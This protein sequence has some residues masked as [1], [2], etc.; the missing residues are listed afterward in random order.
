MERR[1]LSKIFPEWRGREGST[2]FLFTRRVG[3][4]L[5]VLVFA[6][7]II[8]SSSQSMKYS[9]G[10]TKI[11]D[12]Q[13]AP[14][15]GT[16]SNVVGAVEGASV[17][18]RYVTKRRGT[19]WKVWDRRSVLHTDLG[20]TC[21][22]QAFK[23]VTHGGK[24]GKAPVFMCLYP[25]SEDI[26]VSGSIEGGGNWGD[27]HVLTGLLAGTKRDPVYIDIGANIGA[28]VMQV[29]LTTGATV[30]AFEPNP[31]NLFRLTSTL[32][33]LPEELKGR[34]TLFPVALGDETTLTS[35][36]TSPVN[37]GNTQVRR[38][39]EEPLKISGGEQGASSGA[40][41]ARDI[42]V[43]RVDDLLSP[44]LNVDVIKYV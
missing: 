25:R 44:D 34:V 43:E 29:L 13:L 37:A 42:P 35:I 26:Y 31:R 41:E 2:G 39:E 4:P 20:G 22:W 8:W 9:L 32:M 10:I 19:K 30:L 11:L 3:A 6:A 5:L 1:A 14:A 18:D 21:N 33:N 28:C 15:G 24:A 27:C 16:K 40:L 17:V 12:A 36:V 23:P 7:A 38:S